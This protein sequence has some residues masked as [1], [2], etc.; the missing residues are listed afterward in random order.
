[1]NVSPA[2]RLIDIAIAAFL[3]A[4]RIIVV[5]VVVVGTILTLSKGTFT[6]EQWLDLTL[7]GL[8]QGS[9]YALIALGYTMVYGILRMINFAHGEIFMSGAFG[10]YFAAITLKNI[11]WL[12]ASPL[13]ASFLL[14]S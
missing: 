4:F 6:G 10:G 8:R 3:W 9:I 7:D 5:L 14:S 2:E 1:M 11:G 12:N 13:L